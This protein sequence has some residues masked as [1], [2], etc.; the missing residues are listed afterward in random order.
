[1]EKV[2]THKM[3]GFLT[4]LVMVILSV[5]LY[6]SDLAFKPWAQWVSYIPFLVGL[7][8]NAM[9]YAKAN[10][11]YVTYGNVW[12]SG[13]KASA[14]ITIVTLAWALI[15][16][17]VFPE[18]KEKSLELAAE[19]IAENKSVSDEQIETTL[20]MTEKFFYPFMI[21]GIVFGTMF[22]GA[23]FSLIAAAVPKRKGDGLP[24]VNP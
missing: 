7:I 12:T 8:L 4:G 21:A 13:F 23:V 5:I 11:H 6:I 16:M 1:M 3:Y 19:R 20:K 24:P 18:M 14:I 2:Q 9:A 10:D 17:F 22:F 15:A